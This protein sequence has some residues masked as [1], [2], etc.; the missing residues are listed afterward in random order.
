MPLAVLCSLCAKILEFYMSLC[1]IPTFDL[2]SIFFIHTQ[3]HK[4]THTHT[5]THTVTG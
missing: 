1:T 5:H 4:H 2:I 3:T